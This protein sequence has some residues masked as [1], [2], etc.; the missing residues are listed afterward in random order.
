MKIRTLF[1]SLAA[2]GLAFGVASPSQAAEQ[3]GNVKVG[4]NWLGGSPAE[5]GTSGVTVQAFLTACRIERLAMA[6]GQ[7]VPAIANFLSSP[8][9]GHDGYVFDLKAEKMGPFQVKGTGA[10]ALTPELP[11][12]GAVPEYDLDM[13]FYTD[14]SVD[15]GTTATTGCPDVNSKASSGAHKCYAHK[16][17][18]DE[19]TP[20][21]A[22]WKDS[23]GKTH[24]ARYVVVNA[25]LHLKGPMEIKLL[26]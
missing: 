20:C 8:L 13:D 16:I 22:G 14:P 12:I 18:S 3:K 5:V 4:N 19:K 24:G 21:V 23:K 7:K 2:L 25:S 9:N 15:P 10:K 11:V 1:L 6:A 26:F 17:Q